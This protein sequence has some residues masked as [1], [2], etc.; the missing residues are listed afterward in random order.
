MAG[1]KDEV[2]KIFKDKAQHSA[3]HGF[4]PGTA[5]RGRFRW[6]CK[7]RKVEKI[8]VKARVEVNAPFV[9]RDEMLGGI[10]SPLD[11]RKYEHKSALR[12]HYK[13]NGYRETGGDHLKGVPWGTKKYK[14]DPRE[15]RESV[16]KAM[17]DIKYDR[18][19]QTERQKQLNIEEE[20]AWQAYKDRQH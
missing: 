1:Y 6:N 11:G 2:A 7:T 17:A 14:S 3:V 13:E 8:E 19:E 20:R 9:H 10:E 18:V 15:V 5:E 4:G 12:K 16:A